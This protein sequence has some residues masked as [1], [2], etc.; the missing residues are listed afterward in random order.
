MGATG[1]RAVMTEV[2]TMADRG[3]T[4][5]QC[6]AILDRLPPGTARLPYI[7]RIQRLL[8]AGG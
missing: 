4:I 5:E 8:A 6:L 2:A 1:D 3:L 7:E